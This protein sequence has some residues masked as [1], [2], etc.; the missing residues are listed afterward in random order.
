MSAP[1]VI[2]VV[3]ATHQRRHL[4]P[5]LLGALDAQREV[6]PFEV[7]IVD[8]GSTDGTWEELVRLGV[9][10][11]FPLRVERLEN[12]CGPAVARNVG[13]R[14]AEGQLIAF[15]DDDC[16]PQPGWLA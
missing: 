7:I 13:W 15:T 12:N 2:S 9:D 6:G 8:D 1:T 16:V 3:V 4:L 11:R 14:R 5:R 10:A